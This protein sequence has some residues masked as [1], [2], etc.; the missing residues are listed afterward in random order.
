MRPNPATADTEGSALTGCAV[1]DSN[2]CVT[3]P[4]RNPLALCPACVAKSMAKLA[5]VGAGAGAGRMSMLTTT[6]P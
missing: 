1:S 6:L 5:E 2:E 4:V 3:I